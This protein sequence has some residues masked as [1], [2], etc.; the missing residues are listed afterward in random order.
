[1]VGEEDERA[2]VI[3][4]KGG[5]AKGEED[6][7]GRKVANGEAERLACARV[8]DVLLLQHGEAP[9]I[10]GDVL[11]GAH[12]Q[13]GEEDG[14]EQGDVAV[15]DAAADG[16]RQEGHG[17]AGDQLD[18]DDPGLAA[19]E[20]DAVARVDDGGDEQLE[21]VRQRGEGEGGQVRVGGA[22]L[23]EQERD[24]AEGQ[25]HGQPL[26]RVQRDEQEDRVAIA[27]PVRGVGA[28]GL[29]GRHGG[30]ARRWG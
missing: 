12:G 8:R 17:E 24:G 15:G 7:E 29:R 23:L 2:D 21:R 5:V 11:R 13:Q 9:A 22:A 30:G 28:G 3:V 10:D 14:G 1:M 26:G 18:R 6:S 19:A 20:G 27:P 4:A 16:V 25:P